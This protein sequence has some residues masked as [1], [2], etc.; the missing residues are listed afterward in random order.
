ML[1]AAGLAVEPA[2]CVI[3][4]AVG[5]SG[6]TGAVDFFDEAIAYSQPH[7]FIFLGVTFDRGKTGTEDEACVSVERIAVGRPGGGQLLDTIAGDRIEFPAVR[8]PFV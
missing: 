3:S 2:V 8:E 1:D 5:A 4:V 7:D 6:G